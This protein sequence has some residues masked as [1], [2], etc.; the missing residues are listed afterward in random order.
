MKKRVK[1]ITALLGVALLVLLYIL[2]LVFAIFDFEGSEMMF[3][4]CLY[5]TI[6]I[7]ILL[8]VYIY[9]YDK[10]RQNRDMKQEPDQITIHK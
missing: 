4:A 5:G 9:L 3:R 7:P 8:W 10:L 2:S 1:Q 6:I